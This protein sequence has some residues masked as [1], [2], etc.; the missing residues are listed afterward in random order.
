MYSN[1]GGN[2][3]TYDE[4][5]ASTRMVIDSSGNLLVGHT[6]SIYNNINTTST[7]GSSYSSNG[8]IF[9]CSDQ[10]SG[11]MFLN[12]KSSDGA[13]ATFRKDG[14]PVGSIGVAS[15]GGTFD[16]S[17][18]ANDVRITGGNASYWVTAGAFYGGTANTRDL[19]TNTYK[20][21]D[22]YLSG[23][24]YLGGTGSA[25]KL[26]DYEEGTWTPSFT[27][28]GSGTGITFENRYGKYTKIGNRVF[29]D[30]FIVLSSKGTA[31]GSAQVSLPFSAADDAT[32][33][34]HEASFSLGF[35]SGIGNITRVGMFNGKIIFYDDGTTNSTGEADSEFTNSANFRVTGSYKTT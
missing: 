15:S 1:T 34:G 14:S 17:G 35:A 28:D 12:R 4:D 32:F 24:V 16:I 9:A 30:V 25:N 20:W 29:F 11:V 5:A 19:G 21:R 27:F 2:L 13:I 31:T 6:G 22:L 23:G 7:I 10:S 18:A 26:D 3:V 8:E 33:T